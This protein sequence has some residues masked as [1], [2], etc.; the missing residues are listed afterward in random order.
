MADPPDPQLLL[1][2]DPAAITGESEELRH[3]DLDLKSGN[4][5]VKISG[6]EIG[7]K[8]ESLNWYFHACSDGFNCEE[9]SKGKYLCGVG[10][11]SRHLIET[12]GDL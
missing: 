9:G 11:Q 10:V 5:K 8:E 7:G 1:A 6:R 3:E 4:V 12:N 2:G